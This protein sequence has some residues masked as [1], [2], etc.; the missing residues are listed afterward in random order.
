MPDTTNTTDD[1][2]LLALMKKDKRNMAT[3]EVELYGALLAKKLR[4]V[5]SKL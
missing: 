1:D 3:R 4:E 2:L 5:K